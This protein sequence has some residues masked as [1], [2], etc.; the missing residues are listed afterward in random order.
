MKY[1]KHKTAKI[2]TVSVAVSIH[3]SL[4][5]TSPFSQAK[6]QNFADV[7]K[8]QKLWAFAPTYAKQYFHSK[9]YC[10]DMARDKRIRFYVWV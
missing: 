7:S 1:Y 2:S 9:R 6:I 5:E 3:N 4:K 8:C 10:S